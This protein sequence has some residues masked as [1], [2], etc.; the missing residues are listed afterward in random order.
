MRKNM[1]V[2]PFRQMLGVPHSATSPKSKKPAKPRSHLRSEGIVCF[3]SLTA[4]SAAAGDLRGHA[5]P[6]VS[7]LS[8]FRPI[9]GA[10]NN[11]RSPWLNAIPGSP[12]IALTPLNFAPGTNDGLVNG[13]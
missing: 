7:L 6:Q 11:H 3:L 1:D 5:I 2:L 4:L 13:P 12:E 8:E 9:G 10:G